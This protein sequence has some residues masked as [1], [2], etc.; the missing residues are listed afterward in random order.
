MILLKRSRPTAWDGKGE[1]TG[2]VCPT[3]EVLML[4]ECATLRFHVLLPPSREVPSC[5]AGIRSMNRSSIFHLA[6]WPSTSPHSQSESE[7]QR[8]ISLSSS[9]SSCSCS[10]SS[11]SFSFGAHFALFASSSSRLSSGSI[12]CI[13]SV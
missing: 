4:S 13:P 11:P 1:S 3:H 8:S 5:K 9:S 2:Y 12:S 7:P 6:P 10:C